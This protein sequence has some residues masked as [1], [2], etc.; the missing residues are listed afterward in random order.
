MDV[1]MTIYKYKYIYQQSLVSLRIKA[2]LVIK[3]WKLF[4]NPEVFIEHVFTY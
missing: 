3:T 4:V 1:F 2:Y